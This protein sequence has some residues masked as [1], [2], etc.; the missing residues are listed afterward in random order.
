MSL[1]EETKRAKQVKE[2]KDGNLETATRPCQWVT[3]SQLVSGTKCLLGQTT[4]KLTTNRYTVATTFVNFYSNV[5]YIHVQE[6]TLAEEN[7]EAKR[8][9]E[10]FCQL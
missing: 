1:Q 8:A 10:H 6:S 4:G 9:F 3:I 2:K 7:I 5:D